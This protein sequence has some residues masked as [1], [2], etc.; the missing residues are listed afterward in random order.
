MC[1]TAGA[2]VLSGV[3][4]SGGTLFIRAIGFRPQAL[5]VSVADGLA[6]LV[7]RLEAGAQVLPDLVVAARN[8][9]PAKYAWTTKYDGF[10]DRNQRPIP[11]CGS[12]DA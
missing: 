7:V 2:F 9:K 8:A 3:P 12:R 10:F 1:D 4:S 6:S 5:K 11:R